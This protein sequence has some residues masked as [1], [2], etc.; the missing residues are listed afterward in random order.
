MNP[1]IAELVIGRAFA[2]PVGSSGATCLLL[3]TNGLKPSRV[4]LSGIADKVS[5]YEIS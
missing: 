3:E 2:R 4:A 1:D 5:V